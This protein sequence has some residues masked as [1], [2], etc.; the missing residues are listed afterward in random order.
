VFVFPTIS[1]S[2]FY[3]FFA[4][5]SSET[6]LCLRSLLPRREFTCRVVSANQ[7]RRFGWFRRDGISKA[8]VFQ[9]A[10]GQGGGAIG[11]GSDETKGMDPL[12]VVTDCSTGRVSALDANCEHWANPRVEWG[13][14]LSERQWVCSER[15]Q[16]WSVGDCPG[17]LLVR[18]CWRRCWSKWEWRCLGLVPSWPRPFAGIPLGIVHPTRLTS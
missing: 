1:I 14:Y 3:P 18:V 15:V 13:P 5:L 2:T 10:W 16:G 11:A 4:F 12:C 8:D 9:G 17:G 6:R 7:F